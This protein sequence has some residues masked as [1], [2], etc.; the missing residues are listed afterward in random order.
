MFSYYAR[1]VALC[2]LALSASG[3][4]YSAEYQKKLAGRILAV[5]V[6]PATKQPAVL[7]FSKKGSVWTSFIA[8]NADQESAEKALAEQTSEKYDIDLS[9][10]AKLRVSGGLLKDTL[11]YIASVRF[12][13]AK[14]LT[15]YYFE[16]IW[17]PLKEFATSMARISKPN[18]FI[19]KKAYIDYSLQEFIKANNR[20]IELSS[21]HLLPSKMKE[22]EGRRSTFEDPQSYQTLGTERPRERETRFREEVSPQRY[23]QERSSSTQPQ[24]RGYKEGEQRYS[25]SQQQPE[26]Q[27]RFREEGSPQRYPQERYSSTQQQERYYQEGGKRQPYQSQQRPYSAYAEELSE[28]E[29]TEDPFPDI[30]LATLSRKHPNRDTN[31]LIKERDRLEREWKRR[32]PSSPAMRLVW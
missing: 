8:D 16:F 27:T 20:T 9:K 2:M 28:E 30:S 22:P 23:P 19:G 21:K 14:S 25:R 24:E 1:I 17:V 32:N 26:R 13:P 15:T 6:D 31:W 29:P 18:T 3:S 12:I 10:A 5:A 11:F 7:L 4:L